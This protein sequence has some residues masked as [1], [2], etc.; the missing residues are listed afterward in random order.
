MKNGVLAI[1]GILIAAIAV[2]A[3]LSL[4]VVN[5]AQQALVLQFGQIKKTEQEPGLK[6]KIPFVQNV[7]FFDKRVRD[8]NMPP[9]EAIASDK[10]RL[11][12][13]AF[14]R[15]RITNPVLFYQTVNNTNEANQRLATFLQSSLRSVLAR[16]TFVQVVRDERA[17]LMDEIRNDVAARAAPIG[18]DVIDVKI[19][20]AD[21]P[22]TNSEAI[23]RR[24][25]T[26]RQR[27]ATELRAQG[28]EQARRIRSRADRDATVLIAEANRDAEILRGDGDAER[29]GIFAEAFGA[30]PEFFSF[31]R[32]MQAYASGLETSG[33]QMVL[34]P[35]S[36]FFRYFRDPRGT[37]LSP[38]RVP[39]A[40]MPPAT[41]STPQP[42]APAASAQ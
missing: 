16:A 28:E 15:Y 21:L 41:T 32:S 3:Y 12:V 39:A 18:I 40:A 36:E 10:K 24:M 17:E 11:I 42:E 9:I 4:Y 22:Q 27:E 25:Q 26:E 33:T 31:Y 6:V 37:E 23:F 34:S 7:L 8:L 2:V 5:P 19:R 29:T 13:D 20:R 38:T 35:N 1:I 14:A 30:D